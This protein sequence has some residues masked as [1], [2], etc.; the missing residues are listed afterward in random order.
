MSAPSLSVIVP[1]LDNRAG[2]GRTL[3]ALAP[4]LSSRDDVEVIVVDDGST[5]GSGDE[6]AAILSSVHHRIIRTANLGAAA[7]RNRGAAA[8]QG[9]MIAFLDTNDEPR[10][11]W[12]ELFAADRPD[13]VGVI[14]ARP[15][16]EDPTLDTRHAHL[17]PGCFAIAHDLFDTVGGYDEALRF[18]ENTDLVERCHRIA[19][20]TGRTVTHHDVV[21]LAVHDIRDPRHYD[22]RRAEAMSYL[23]RRDA[24]T[25]D[26]ATL[27]RY[28][29]VGAVAAARSGRPR[30][31]RRMAAVA[32]G[33]RPWSIRNWARMVLVGLAPLGRR[34]W[35]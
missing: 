12:V 27:E 1:V 14:H 9:R 25:A 31:A 29:R 19:D 15:W 21:I 8:A 6:A 34:R 28:A 33:K 7:A 24:A 18:A 3:R 22:G 5:D 32:I 2:L 11:G 17:L 30:D 26:A 20:A 35:R 13:D 10:P 4:Q 23:L 16:L